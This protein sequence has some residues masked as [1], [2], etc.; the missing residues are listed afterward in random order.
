MSR[1]LITKAPAL[2]AIALMLAGG[3]SLWGCR[4]QDSSTTAAAA[5]DVPPLAAR[6]DRL[7]GDVGTAAQ[8]Q[9][10]QTAQAAQ[11]APANWV[12]ASVNTPVS[13]GTRVYVKPGS[14]SAIAFSGRNYARLNPDTACDVVAL[15]QRRTQ[16]ALH[17]GSG[18]FDVGALAPDEL[19]EVATPDGAIDFDKPG[20]Y[21]VAIGDDGTAQCSVL[22]G[23]AHF[24]G[25]AGTGECRQRQLLTLSSDSSEDAYVSELDQGVCGQI[26]DD[27]YSYRYPDTYD[28]RYSDY[29]RYLDDP[30]YYDPYRRSVS[31]EYIPDDA[32]V[33]GLDDLDSNGDW[34]DVPN[35]GHC[36]HPRVNQGWAPYRDGEWRDDGVLG[37]TWVANERWGWAPYHYGR[38]VDQNQQW[39]WVPGEVV[40]HPVYSPA[41]VA[42]VSLP[43]QDRVGWVPLGP[44]DPYVPRYY[45][46]NYQP[47]YI[48]SRID[49]DRNVNVTTV[50]NYNV[51]GAVTI[52]PTNQ[53]TRVITPAVAL[54]VDAAMLARARPEMDPFAVPR[55]REM[56]PT[57]QATRPA[58]QVPVTVVQQAYSRPVIVSQNPVVPTVAAA[59]LKTMNVQPV[60]EVAAKRKVQ[61]K[62]TGQVVAVTQ[63]NG[64]PIPVAP[65]VQRNQG[66]NQPGAQPGKQPPN[67]GSQAQNQAPNQNM[68]TQERQARIAALSAQ[69]A[70]GNKAAKQEVRQLQEQQRVQDKTDR[71]AAAQ[72]AAQQQAQQAQQAQQQAAQQA[73]QRK[74]QK[75]AAQQAAQ[76]QQQQA[77][78]QAAQQAQQRKAQKQAAQ[79]AAQQQ[80]QQAA[81][82]AAQRKAERQAAQQKAQQAAQQQQQQ[83]AQQAAQRKAERQAAQQKAQQAAQ[84]QQQQ[85]AQQAAQRK[86][87]R[88]AAQQK[89]QQAAQQQQQQAA[90]QAAQRKAE[91]QAAQQKAQ[92]AAQQQQQQAAQQAAQRKAERQAAQ[93]KAQQAAQQQQQ[94]S[95]Q[96]AQQR[97]QQSQQAAQQR[98]QQSQQAAQQRQQQ[99]QQAAQQRQQQRAQRQAQQQQQQQ[100][101]PGENPKK[102]NKNR[103][104]S[105]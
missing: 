7:D 17:S 27:Y 23:S 80:Q 35:Y 38:W 55:L 32:E 26:V 11:A 25:Q 93:Q 83:A 12:K 103:N 56:A 72:Q 13:V 96:A 43:Q 4:S 16:L 98:Q 99:S 31:H 9:D 52:V 3:L 68:T 77:A 105:Q 37:L 46:R 69:A 1:K 84:Q 8:A 44:G 88:Q 76:Q 33:A 30:Y 14:H 102:K 67:A 85:A 15:T 6:V 22:A 51:P 101:A 42:F 40:S 21:Q 10:G 97:Q 92:Q 54:A 18:V 65:R 60:P 61:V 87:E 78:Q 47:Q 64:P 2:L 66:Q 89:A 45:D 70:Q 41:M 57:I 71:Q 34:Q 81:Q 59:N 86:P 28:H 79:Q 90:Q 62:D 36:W 19:F 63:P 50:V 39:Y 100:Q 91:R 20:L 48:G 5:N 53:F 73:E 58:V 24:V 94:Q 104:S 29:N 82:Q 49:I 74:A 95:Q 75:Q